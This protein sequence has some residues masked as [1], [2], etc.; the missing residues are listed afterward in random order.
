MCHEAMLWEPATGGRVI[1]GLCAHRCNIPK[2]EFGFCGMRENTGD[3]LYTRAYGRVIADNVDP[4]EKKP[5]YHFLPGTYAYSIATFGCNFRCSFCQNWTISQVSAKDSPSAGREMSPEKIVEEAAENNCKSISYTYT[6]PTVFFE[7]AYDTSVI[8]KERGL[9][10]TFVTNGFMTAEAVEKISPYLDA[11]NVDLKFFKDDQYRKVCGGRLQPV[12]DS[13]GKM[14]EK[15]IWI[16]VTTLVIPGE[17]DS[18][19][20]LS[21]MA[22][23]LAGVDKGMPWHISRFHPDYRYTDSVPTPLDTMKK[24]A[25]IGKKAGLEYVYLGNVSDG[26]ETFCPA[27]GRVMVKRSG[28]GVEVTK[29]LKDGKCAGCG[30]EIGGVWE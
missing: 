10:N 21:G 3:R 11:A 15:G 12:L 24:A 1:C 9:Y 28:S 29:D 18:E 13:I 20:E 8:A 2:G 7:Y 27:C 5:L 14:K 25:D 30:T 16:E 22:E 26:G 6:E 4:I 19:E 23:F 17:N